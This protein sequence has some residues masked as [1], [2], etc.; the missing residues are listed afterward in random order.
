MKEV[1]IVHG[2]LMN[3]L[4]MKV[5]GKRFKAKGWKVHYFN[6]DS[7]FFEKETTL[8][9]LKK[10]VDNIKGDDLYFVGHSMGGLVIRQFIHD[11]PSVRHKRVVTLGT[12]HNKSTFA[13]LVSESL[14]NELFGINGEAGLI[15]DLKEWDSETEIG[16]IAGSKPFGLFSVFSFLAPKKTEKEHL[17]PHDGTIL[18]KETQL[19]GQEDHIVL[20]VSHTGLV[21]SKE[22][23]EQTI[24]F[25]EK[26]KFK[27]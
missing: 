9:E 20:N 16:S 21:Y 27:K 12:P 10:L 8:S 23:F 24:H 19:E 6:Y 11:N 5:I 7:T 26:G 1:I 3:S 13:N 17:L 14:L 15:A 25:F 4:V 2:F 18:V 22:A